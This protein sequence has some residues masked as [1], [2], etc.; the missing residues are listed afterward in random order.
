MEFSPCLKDNLNVAKLSK[1]LCKKWSFQR[2]K[3]HLQYFSKKR[4]NNYELNDDLNSEDLANF[5][6]QYSKNLI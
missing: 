2:F 4:T 5:K 1:E 3:I 6:G